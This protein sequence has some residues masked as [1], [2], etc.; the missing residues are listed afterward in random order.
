MGAASLV[1]SAIALAFAEA[2]ADVAVT[3]AT[4]EAEE[5]YEVRRLAKRIGEMR[6]R[7]MA[8]AVD[9]SSGTGVQITVRQV[10]KELGGIDVLVVATGA[11]AGQAVERL[12]D[13]DWAKVLGQ[14]LSAVF[15]ACRSVAR[16]MLRQEPSP[17]G[18]RGIIMILTPPGEALADEQDVAYG[19]AQSGV[20]ALARGLVREWAPQGIAVERIEAS[21]GSEDEASSEE[22]ASRALAMVAQ[23]R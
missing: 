13:A 1:G 10:A 7:S 4:P 2:G 12:S 9:L 22:A 21:L 16:E 8:E 19:A 3:T 11:R 20:V 5:A 23:L 14:N 6:R 18:S 15:Y 17:D